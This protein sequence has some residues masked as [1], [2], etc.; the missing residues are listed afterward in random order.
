MN[1]A[2][3]SRLFKQVAGVSFVEYL[4]RV[5]MEHAKELLRGDYI[6]MNEVARLVGYDD[7]QY[8]SKAFKK[9]EGMS[10]SGFRKTAP[11]SLF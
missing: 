8:F 3:F 1:S 6:K 9:Y 10:P 5:R 4:T 11:K 2:Y 7:V